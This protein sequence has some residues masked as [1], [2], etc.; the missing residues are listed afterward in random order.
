MK[1]IHKE[2]ERHSDFIKNLKPGDFCYINS[3]LYMVI[4]PSDRYWN[5]MVIKLE[6]GKVQYFNHNISVEPVDCAMI[7]IE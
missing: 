4:M 5:S 1:I 6:T 7:V 2:K 3:A